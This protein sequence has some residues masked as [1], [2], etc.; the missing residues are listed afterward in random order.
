M[1]VGF[2]QWAGSG[3]GEKGSG[4]SKERERRKEREGRREGEKMREW[5]W[6][7]TIEGGS[8]AEE[9]R[10]ERKQW[11]HCLSVLMRDQRRM[12]TYVWRPS[13]STGHTATH[14][15]TASCPYSPPT[16]QQN[17]SSLCHTTHAGLGIKHFD[18]NGNLIGE[19]EHFFFWCKRPVQSGLM[20]TFVLK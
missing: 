5:L 13:P 14:A 3:K 20:P 7:K 17:T 12:D 8:K 6:H 16:Q 18:Q 4:V 10:A 11:A 15:Q 1:N 9:V 19:R 2:K